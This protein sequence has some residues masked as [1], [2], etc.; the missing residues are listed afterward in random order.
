MRFFADAVPALGN[1]HARRGPPSSLLRTCVEDA[2]A[3][4]PSGG[5]ACSHAGA[6][7]TGWLVT[8]SSAAAGT[9]MVDSFRHTEE[10][11]GSRKSRG[12]GEDTHRRRICDA[13]YGPDRPIDYDAL[14]P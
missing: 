8:F 7:S 9:S 14:A 6:A 4:S 11:V 3:G 2:V 10:N 1:A 13:D 5:T 12:K